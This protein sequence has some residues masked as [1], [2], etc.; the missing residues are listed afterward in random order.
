MR[1]LFTSLLILFTTATPVGATDFSELFARVSPS[2]V[3]VHTR[4]ERE[5]AREGVVEHQGIG[6]GVLID[7]GGRV[8]T[9][10]HLV[11]LA[12]AIQVGF[13]GGE[14][15]SARVVASEPGADVALL[16]LEWVPEG[17]V[18]VELGNST[19]AKVG[20]EVVVIGAPLG[21]EH[22]LSVGHLSGR[23]RGGDL[24]AG[25]ML[26]EFLQTDAAINEGNSGGPMFNVDGEVI[27]IVSHINSLSGGS[28][29]I[30]FAVSSDAVRRV[31]LEKRGFWSGMR[32]APLGGPMAEALNIPQPYGVLV[33]VVAANSS[34][35][36]AGI[37]GGWI[38]AEIEG[39]SILLGGDVILAVDGVQ[40]RGE[41]QYP[42]MRQYLASKADD[43]PVMLTVFRGGEVVDLAL[44]R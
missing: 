21:V 13:R 19:A 24:A 4:A 14:R 41:S 30:G 15:V 7:I 43:E 40:L 44:E 8:V 29:G 18:A 22:S 23:H 5:T 31:L 1:I 27:G 28:D 33:Q 42:A 2:V 37:R 20:E 35:A 36:R 38:E 10:S 25:F 26:G 32:G 39:E 12:D 17:A 6:S 11:H 16:E 9:A 3:V 34:A